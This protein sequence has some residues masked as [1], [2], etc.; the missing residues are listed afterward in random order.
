MSRTL[1]A[2]ARAWGVQRS[3]LLALLLGGSA[4]LIAASYVGLP[5]FTADI[6]ALDLMPPAAAL[7][8]VSPLVDQT[9]E[10]TLR[11]GRRLVEVL[12]LRYA[13]AHTAG[14]I[15]VASLTLSGWTLERSLAVVLFL[16]GSAVGAAL[17]DG[18]YWVP[19]MGAAYAWL[20]RSQQLQTN[21]DADIPIPAAAA[22]LVVAGVLYVAIGCYRV[23]RRRCPSG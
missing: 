4:Q 17:L 3:L 11:A 8:L 21:A 14:A 9:P 12:S 20:L 15:V 19:V 7:L 10:L 6:P 1:V 2:V 18:W 16:A 13:A 23:H 22:G 5:S